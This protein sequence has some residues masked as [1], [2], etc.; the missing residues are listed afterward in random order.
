[1]VLQFWWRHLGLAHSPHHGDDA[2]SAICHRC[3]GSASA[4]LP[5]SSNG[6][7]RSAFRSVVAAAIRNARRQGSAQIS[8]HF[9]WQIQKLRNQLGGRDIADQ[10]GLAESVFSREIAEYLADCADSA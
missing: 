5:S 9:M 1:M 10:G 7:I 6:G 4:L 8:L 2:G 3:F